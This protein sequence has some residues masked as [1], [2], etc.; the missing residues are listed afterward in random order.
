MATLSDVQ[1]QNTSGGEAVERESD[2]QT[3]VGSAGDILKLG[4]GQG[5]GGQRVF[6][7]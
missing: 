7:F 6:F 1:R 5:E 2:V 3:S 4:Q